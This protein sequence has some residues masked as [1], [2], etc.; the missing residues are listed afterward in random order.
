MEKLCLG[1][2]YTTTLHIINSAIVKLGKLMPAQKVYR[3]I[4]GGLL[5]DNFWHQN[6]FNVRGGVEVRAALRCCGPTP[7]PSPE[8]RQ[9]TR[10]KPPCHLSPSPKPPAA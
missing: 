9:Y 3:G 7:E 10:S 6:E 8:P 2:K 4:A 5:P 1:N